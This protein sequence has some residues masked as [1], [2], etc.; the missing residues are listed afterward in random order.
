[1]SKQLGDS[2]YYMHN[3]IESEKWYAKAIQSQQ[4]AEAYYRYAQML[5]SNGKYAESNTQ[6]KTFANLMPNDQRAITF[7]KNPNFLLDLNAV[8][9]RFEVERISLNSE[10]FDFGAVLYGDVLYFAS[11]RN[12]S[13]KI[14]GW[15]NEPYL[16]IYQ[17]TCNADGSYA[18]PISVDELNSEFHEGPLT[19]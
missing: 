3:T 19:M 8:E 13:S 1:M 5:K 14:Y 10:R 12:E 11:A 15:N 6:M 2:Y 9:K 18:E 16:D 4:D 17:S 7:T